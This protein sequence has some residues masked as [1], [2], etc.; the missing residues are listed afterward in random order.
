MFKKNKIAIS[1]VT[2]ILGV[3][4]IISSAQAV[5]VNPEGTGQVLLF[6][7]YNAQEGYITNINLV[8][9]TSETKAVRIRIKEGADS[10][11]VRDFN[12]YLSPE[13]I[14]T[15]S[16]K[17][18]GGKGSIST[19]DRSCA[20]P[21]QMTATCKDGK[22]E[23]SVDFDTA[24]FPVKDS[25]T[26][27]GYVEVIEMGVV[28]NPKVVAGVNHLDGQPVNCGAVKDA[29]YRNEF[30]Q[31]SG[32][33]AAG[34]TAPTG[35]LFGSSAILNVQEGTAVAV[36]PIA[37]ENYT[38]EPYHTK[39][40]D[41]LLFDRPS[42]ASGSVTTS[43]VLI[44]GSSPQLLKTEWNTL[45]VD[46]CEAE[47]YPACGKNPYP[48]AHALQAHS[49]MNEYFVDP[50][51]N[52]DGHT[53]WVV[54]LPMKR[55]GIF[56]RVVQEQLEKREDI[57]PDTQKP[58][59]KY[60]CVELMP[61]G[62]EKFYTPEEIGNANCLR[63]GDARVS[64]GE[65][66]FDREEGRI[67]DAMYS[68]IGAKPPRILERE[69]NILVF[70]STDPSYVEKSLLKSDHSLPASKSYY[71]GKTVDPDDFV[72][73]GAFVSG[74]ARMQFAGDYDLSTWWPKS[75]GS[76]ADTPW[77]SALGASISSP[78]YHG[79]PVTGFSAVEGNVSESPNTRFG[80][81]LPHK[82]QRN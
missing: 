41:P 64:F 20:Y 56:N 21:A 25:D 14:W 61:G 45:T 1:V 53:D 24:V 66:I 30:Q 22:C 76:R 77:I 26:L 34:L 33:K 11:D 5:H 13:D 67:N 44:G 49:L 72:N 50:S 55:Y 3:V 81:A 6:P 16:I 28:T 74:W 57:N 18:N 54:T 31:G 35:G 9:S 80:D 42:L 12:V 27:E 70:T 32:S 46:P 71:S 29:W 40:D 52:Y 62:T 37:L 23:A 69:V 7:Y 19:T 58:T 79:V 2:G 4:G 82:A 73:V 8:N 75:E 47:G 39:P 48:V 63:Y 43:E 68:P 17:A 36:D 51:N 15:G 59:G 60:Q 10:Y 65:N 78:I 38:T